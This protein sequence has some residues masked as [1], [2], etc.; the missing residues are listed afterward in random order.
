MKK[1]SCPFGRRRMRRRDLIVLAGGAGASLSFAAWAQ[2]P[3]QVRRVGVL[4]PF[5]ENDPEAKNRLKQF[6]FGMRDLDWVEGRDVLID[7]RFAGA[8]PQSIERCVAELI[9]G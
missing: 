5:D 6:R 1:R 8:N 7:F 2:S 9:T 3:Q 4:L